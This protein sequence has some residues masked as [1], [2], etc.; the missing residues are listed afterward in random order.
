[1]GVLN[2]KRCKSVFWSSMHLENIKS[3]KISISAVCKEK[4]DLFNIDKFY[5]NYIIKGNKNYKIYAIKYMQ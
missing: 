3:P 1:M 4:K 5:S 2:E